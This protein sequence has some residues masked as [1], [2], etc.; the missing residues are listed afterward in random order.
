M[1][2]LLLNIALLPLFYK[3]FGRKQNKEMD[4]SGEVICK[5]CGTNFENRYCNNCGQDRF[6]GSH[7]SFKQM[8]AAFFSNIFYDKAWNTTIKLLFRPGFLS[9]EY[10]AGRIAPYTLP[11]KMFWVMVLAF[12]IVYSFNDESSFKLTRNNDKTLFKETTE[13]FDV[14]TGVTNEIIAD[15]NTSSDFFQYFPYFMLLLI[16]IYAAFLKLFFKKEKYAFSINLI[17]TVHLHTFSFFLVTF[18]KILYLT[19]IAFFSENEIF[20]AISLMVAFLIIYIYSFVAAVKFYNNR[21]K[22]NVIFRMFLIGILY[23]IALEFL[24][25]ILLLITTF[26]WGFDGFQFKLG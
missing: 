15:E 3:I 5:N 4:F 11:F 13:F 9:K 23:I 10:V 6:A 20:S 18:S 2:H 8:A 24:L 16:P 12:T 26:L 21:K 22:I 7:R 1:K 14:K 17:F 19:F 25:V